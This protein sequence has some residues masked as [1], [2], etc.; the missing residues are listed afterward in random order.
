MTAFTSGTQA[1]DGRKVNHDPHPWQHDMSRSK[2]YG[3]NDLTCPEDCDA[4]LDPRPEFDVLDNPILA[5]FREA[6]AEG[7]PYADAESWLA[8]R[9]RQPRA[10]TRSASCRS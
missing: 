6:I 8:G 7:D 10:R 1:R 9:I 5:A 2:R 3:H 4:V